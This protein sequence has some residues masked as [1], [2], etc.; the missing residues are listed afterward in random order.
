[1]NKI[2]L[3]VTN[4]CILLALISNAQNNGLHVTYGGAL[5]LSY[6]GNLSNSEENGGRTNFR[7]G[8]GERYHVGCTRNSPSFE[9]KLYV[10]GSLVFLFGKKANL[11]EL[12]IGLGNGW[13]KRNNISDGTYILL[14]TNI[15]YRLESGPFLL[16]SGAGEPEIL[17]AG[18]GI[19]F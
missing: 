15:G 2:T 7:L 3:L 5:T 8:V 14:L 11:F 1:M 6:E 18:V 4:I 19:R 17:Y 9:T 10:G 12:S 13:R 16:R